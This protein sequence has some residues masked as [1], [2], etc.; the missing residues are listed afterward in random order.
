[1][2]KYTMEE[3]LAAKAKIEAEA[4]SKEVEALA[5]LHC[6]FQAQWKWRAQRQVRSYGDH[7]AF[8]PQYDD[9]LAWEH[10]EQRGLLERVEFYPHKVQISVCTL[11]GWWDLDEV[12]FYTS[13]SWR[14]EEIVLFRGNEASELFA[15]VAQQFLSQNKEGP[16]TMLFQEYGLPTLQNYLEVKMKDPDFEREFEARKVELTVK[17]CCGSTGECDCIP[18]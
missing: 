5:A 3:V 1:M 18:F 4:Q 15:Q 8:K 14:M 16:A 11:S 2:H 17:G 10:P 12:E 6:L 9:N 7:L 13:A